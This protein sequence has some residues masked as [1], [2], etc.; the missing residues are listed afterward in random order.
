MGPYNNRLMREQRGYTLVELMAA[1]A[2][3]GFVLTVTMVAFM[4]RNR[5]MKD[6]RETILAYQALANEAEYMRRK[7]YTNVQTTTDFDSDTT[8]LTPLQ[9]CTTTIDVAETAG[10]KNVT[11][12]IRWR[13]EGRVAQLLLIRTDTGGKN[14][15]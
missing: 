11:M 15:W 2:I 1:L 4:D 12:T 14:L 8:L 13:K 9:P 5:R 7:N 3:L 10:V 6:A